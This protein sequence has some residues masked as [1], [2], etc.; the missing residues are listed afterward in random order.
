MESMTYLYLCT[1]APRSLKPRARSVGS[2][3]S[4][5]PVFHITSAGFLGNIS[6]GRL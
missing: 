3:T 5:T 2:R 4:W 6:L 1:K